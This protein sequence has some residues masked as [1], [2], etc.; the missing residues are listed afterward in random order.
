MK[1]AMI[2]D[3]E[4]RD[5]PYE[6]HWTAYAPPRY[7]AFVIVYGALTSIAGLLAGLLLGWLFWG[8]H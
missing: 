7:S 6:V 8:R 1:P 4:K 5:G 3:T 2:A